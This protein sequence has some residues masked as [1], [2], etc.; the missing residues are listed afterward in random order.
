MPERTEQDLWVPPSER[1]ETLQSSIQ[2]L[3]D[4]SIT[5]INPPSIIGG[6][7]FIDTT[8]IKQELCMN[9]TSI[10][11]KEASFSSTGHLLNKNSF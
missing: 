8:H 11:V 6:I 5:F 2:L 10:S 9:P 3:F 1:M 4:Q 7:I